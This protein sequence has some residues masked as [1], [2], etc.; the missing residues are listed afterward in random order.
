MTDEEFERLDEAIL[1]FFTGS[2]WDLIKAYLENEIYQMQAD[3][4]EAKSWDK[5]NELRGEAKGINRI[6]TLRDTV[7]KAQAVENAVV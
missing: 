3:A 2:E 1:S 4:L 6:L 5:V 7:K